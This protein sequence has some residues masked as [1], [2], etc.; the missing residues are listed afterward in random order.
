MGQGNAVEGA[1]VALEVYGPRGV[2]RL[3]GE[4]LSL[5]YVTPG[6]AVKAKEVP[7]GGAVDGGEYTVTAHEAVH[8]VPC[9]GYVLE[10][11]P[12]PGRFSVERAEALGVPTGPLFSRLQEGETVRV[13][14]RTVR[15][16]DV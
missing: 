8:T 10:E 12:R 5:G 1:G 16:E 3:G 13:G 4:L 2:E 11:R 15:P 14:N 7:P 6:F 9:Q